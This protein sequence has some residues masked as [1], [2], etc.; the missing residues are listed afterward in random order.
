MNI[1][2][3]VSASDAVH[4]DLPAALEKGEAKLKEFIEQR[5]EVGELGFHEKLPK[6]KLKT[7]STMV[8]ETSVSVDK[9]KVVVKADHGLFA[10]MI[11]FAQS[12]LLNLRDFFSYELGPLSWVLGDSGRTS[13]KDTEV[14]AAAIT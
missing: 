8:K 13:S 2:S 9:T 4:C 3:G 6:L 7:F 14:K 5:L 1:A 12:R 10:H 11:V